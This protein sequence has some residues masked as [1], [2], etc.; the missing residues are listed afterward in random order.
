[1]SP[2]KSRKEKD[3]MSGMSDAA[4]QRLANKAGVV[5]MSGEAYQEVLNMIYIATNDVVRGGLWATKHAGRRRMNTRDMVCGIKNA[6][7]P[8]VME[9][10]STGKEEELKRCKTYEATHKTTTAIKRVRFYQRQGEC[11]QFAKEGFERMVRHIGADYVTD[12]SFTANGLA[13][14]QVTLEN[15]AVRLLELAN[16]LAIHARRRTVQN[17]DI[18]LAR[19]IG[20]GKMNLRAHRG[21]YTA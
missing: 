17:K 18:R 20:K 21:R 19:K 15:F 13:L 1:M 14:L 6:S 16:E 11:L 8:F 2:K 10:L 4:V 5:A 7:E 12:A 3:H 9:V